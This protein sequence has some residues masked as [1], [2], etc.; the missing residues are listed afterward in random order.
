MTR[1]ARGAVLVATIVVAAAT[2]IAVAQ[3]QTEMNQ[4]AAAR[5]RTAEAEMKRVIGE[6]ESKGKGESNAL[7]SLRNAQAAWEKYRDAQVHALW[8][9]PDPIRYGSVNPM[10]VA[11][12]K[13]EMTRARTRELRA[14]MNPAEGNACSSQWPE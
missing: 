8:P 2:F 9:S 13:A 4:E 11:D 7:E 5:L 12:T 10:C 6:L 3:T 1:I 14:T